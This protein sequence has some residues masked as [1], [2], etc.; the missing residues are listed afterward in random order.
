MKLETILNAYV[1]ADYAWAE[2]WE[3]DKYDRMRKAFRARILKM[4]EEKDRD[5]YLLKE[6]N[7]IL[8][9]LMVERVAAK[10]KRIAE[11]EAA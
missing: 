3:R 7:M 1:T 4:F 11:L 9:K 10:D 8:A 2:G 6:G 5:I